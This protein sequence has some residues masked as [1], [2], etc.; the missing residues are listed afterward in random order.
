VD[1]FTVV[2]GVNA[3]TP[4]KGFVQSFPNRLFLYKFHYAGRSL[5]DTHLTHL[6]GGGD[7]Q[8]AVGIGERAKRTELSKGCGIL[9]RHQI[10]IDL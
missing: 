9:R 2:I 1:S 3:N 5:A 8:L 4:P 7:L 10:L 6:A